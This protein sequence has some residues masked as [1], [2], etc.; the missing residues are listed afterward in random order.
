M[1]VTQ[2]TATRAGSE[3][4]RVVVQQLLSVPTGEGSQG[5]SPEAWPGCLWGGAAPRFWGLVLPW[6]PKTLVTRS[7]QP[8]AGGAG[9]E[10]ETVPAG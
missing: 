8:P 2:P 10:G 9:Q 5:P 1:P 3:R 4:P 7:F 6:S